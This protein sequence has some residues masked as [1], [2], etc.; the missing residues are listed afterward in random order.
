MDFK[1]TDLLDMP[2]GALK[3]KVYSIDRGVQNTAPAGRS[4]VL[5]W[6]WKKAKAE[7]S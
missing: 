4:K 5:A 7:W 1:W 3:A 6:L 2:T